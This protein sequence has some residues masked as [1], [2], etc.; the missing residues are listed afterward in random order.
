MSIVN[1]FLKT[2]LLGGVL[3]LL[4]FL[5]FYLLFSE[6]LELV[7]ALAN[8]VM[9]ILPES[10]SSRFGDPLVL[11][12]IIL[13]TG[14]FLTGLALRS[15]KLK[16]LGHWTERSFLDKMPLYNSVKRLSQGIL[17]VKGD[18]VF[19]CGFME[20]VTGIRELVYIV[21]NSGNGYMTVM[22]PLAPSGFSGPLKI[23]DSEF[24][25]RIEASIGEASVPVSEW[26]VGLQKLL[27]CQAKQGASPG[28][29]Q[30][31]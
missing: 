20:S 13:V 11:A 29:N 31:N 28:K 15:S 6:L 14:A 27:D 23:V 17:G 24:V 3:V 22:V 30:N 8:P 26:G 25:T 10:I 7:T 9:E 5:L 2:T 16:S 21:E 4:P 18:D 1:N 19:S 12:L